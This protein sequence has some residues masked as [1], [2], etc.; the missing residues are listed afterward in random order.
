M[1]SWMMACVLGALALTSIGCVSQPDYDRLMTA[2][3]QEKEQVVDL[4]GQVDELRARVKALQEANRPGDQDLLKKLQDALKQKEDLETKVAQMEQQLR[5][6]GAETVVLPGSVDQALKDLAAANPELLTY[7]PKR[8]MV[9]FSADLTFDLGSDIVKPAAVRV[10]DKFAQVMKLPDAAKYE[11]LIV[12]HTDNVRIAKPS[13]RAKYPTNWHLSVYRAIAVKDVLA[14]AGVP[15]SRFCVAGYGQYRPIV[16]NGPHGAQANRRVE[17]YLVPSTASGV[18][19]SE[20]GAT[21]APTPAAPP[22]APPADNTPPEM[23]K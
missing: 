22:A 13:T 11:A 7:D 20:A 8:G 10:L 3:K 16:P 19:Q 12:G 18:A 1:K 4:Q 6:L 21:A 9:K 5:A 17:I 14:K 2:Y 23:F 15:Q